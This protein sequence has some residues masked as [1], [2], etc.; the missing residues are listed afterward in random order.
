VSTDDNE[1]AEVARVSGAEVIR[2]PA[3]LATDLSASEPALL[4]VLDVLRDAEGYE[5]ELVVFLQCT[6]PVRTSADVDR[7]VSV[8]E[9]EGADAVLSVV[10]RRMFLWSIRDG[11][12]KPC[13]Y[14]LSRRPRSQYMVPVFVENGSIYVMRTKTLRS[15]GNRL[16]GQVAL[17]EMG[18]ESMVDIDTPEDLAMCEAVF[19]R[20]GAK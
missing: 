7:A 13:T 6:C 8:L 19:A 14:D 15:T 17:L 4:H 12:P 2:R 1:I 10:P 20:S 9:E 11:Q 5:P 16:G 18:P 3:E